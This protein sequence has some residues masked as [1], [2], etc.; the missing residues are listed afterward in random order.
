MAP[1]VKANRWQKKTIA[2]RFWLKVA[3]G[4]PDD[5]WLWLAGR[6][7][8]YGTFCVSKDR[9]VRAHIFSYEMTHGA[10]LTYPKV[11]LHSCDNTLC[12]NPRHLSVGTQA[13][14]MADMVSKRRGSCG[15]GERHRS[16]KLAENDV[17]AI[18][19]SSDTNTALA[20]RYGVKPHTISNVRRGVTWRQVALGASQ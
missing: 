8:P 13:D 15:K 1:A 16:A 18:R 11:V 5:C 10:V 12:C 17:R 9:H 19:A 7:G 2:E 3:K 4:G 20:K 14:N 6:S